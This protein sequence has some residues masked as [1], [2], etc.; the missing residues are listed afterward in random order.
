MQISSSYA[1]NNYD[2]PYAK[3]NET[4]MDSNEDKTKVQ[5]LQEDR[6]VKIDND[7]EK[8]KKTN[9]S[10][11]SK[12]EELTPEEKQLVKDLQARDQ[13]VRAHEAAHLAVAGSLAA[14]GASFTYQKGPDG[15]QYAIGGEVPIEVSE[16]RTPEE[17][18]MKARQIKAAAVAPA[19]PSAQDMKIAS[20]AAMM[21]MKALMEITAEKMEESN[22]ENKTNPY[23]TSKNDNED[24]PLDLIA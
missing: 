1:Y 2:N 7:D 11:T 4:P 18:V 8:S 23:D 12:D 13:E 22:K 17:T 24:S 10:S 15:K 21:E 14:G 9:T 16:G 6:N 20:T 3:V 5:S 19:N